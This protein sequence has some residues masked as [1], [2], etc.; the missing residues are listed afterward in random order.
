MKDCGAHPL[1]ML[2]DGWHYHTL[3]APSEEHLDLLEVELR[4]KHYL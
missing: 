1:N 4:K 3:V 2:T